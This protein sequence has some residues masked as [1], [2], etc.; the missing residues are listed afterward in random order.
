[1]S[2]KN[3]SQFG[4]AVRPAIGDIYIYECLVLLYRLET[5][6]NRSS[7]ITFYS[8]VEFTLK[9]KKSRFPDYQDIN[10]FLIMFLAHNQKNLV[11]SFLL[12]FLTNVK[13]V[14]TF[15]S[16]I[17]KLTSYD[18][19]VTVFCMPLIKIVP[20]LFVCKNGGILYI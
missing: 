4:P 8:Y 9:R 5:F 2:T 11:D 3:V 19:S 17:V 7:L 16:K 6:S 10:D 13:N 15:F 12:K 1:M 14:K 18:K 20:F